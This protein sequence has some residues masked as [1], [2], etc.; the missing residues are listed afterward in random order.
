MSITEFNSELTPTKLSTPG[1]DPSHF[2]PYDTI[3]NLNFKANTLLKNLDKLAPFLQD[4]GHIVEE[5]QNGIV[6]LLSS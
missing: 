2:S 5:L 6:G 4:Q 3:E 1:F